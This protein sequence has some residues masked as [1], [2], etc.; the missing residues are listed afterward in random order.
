[1]RRPVY[2]VAVAVAVL[3]A[4]GPWA[5]AWAADTAAPALNGL[6]MPQGYED[7]PVISVTHRLDN[8]T[9][10][11]ILGNEVAVKAAR[12]G[13]TNPWPDGS[14]LGKVVWKEKPKESWPDAIA[15]DTLVHV[16]FMYKDSVKFAG[17]GTGWGWARWLG[18]ELKPYGK[19]ASAEQ[20]CIAC[21]MSRKGKDWVFTVPAPMP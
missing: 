8:K 6:V 9:M 15:P 17:N 11:V 5:V 18:K 13:Q 20:E 2:M 10:R 16:E 19:D 4:T 14:I 12:A 21:H 1:M 7:W 3:F